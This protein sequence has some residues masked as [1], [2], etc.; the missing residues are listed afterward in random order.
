MSTPGI[1]VKKVGMTR[2]VDSTGN[3][4]AVTLVQA[5]D[6]QVT[7]ILTLESNGYSAVQI[8][9]HEKR[10]KHLTKADKARLEKAGITK[11]YSDFREMRC[12]PEDAGVH[13]IGQAVTVAAFEGVSAVDVT[14][15]VKG[16]GFQGTTRRWNTRT[17]RRTH[18]S[19]YHRRGGSIG[20][21]TTPG[22]VMKNKHMPG[23]MGNVNS[24]VQNLKVVD[25]DTQANVIALKGSI[26]GHRDSYLLL[27]PSIKVKSEN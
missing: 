6:Q 21:R 10:D 7:K 18:G 17:G 25:L 11:K 12:T 9:Y 26:P 20:Q 24:T 8:G 4:I 23:Q 2:I 1:I 16:R 13:Q 15:V 14:G 5:D 27:R 3:M 19:R 22:K